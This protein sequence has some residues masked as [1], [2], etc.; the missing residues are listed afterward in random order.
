MLHENIEPENKMT[1]SLAAL[2]GT[3]GTRASTKQLGNVTF[4]YTLQ[5]FK[6]IKIKVL[7]KEKRKEIK[8]LSLYSS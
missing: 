7:K 4:Q 1:Q 8:A 2:Y 5:N 3:F 6:S